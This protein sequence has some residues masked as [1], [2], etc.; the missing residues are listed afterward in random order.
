MMKQQDNL[1]LLGEAMRKSDTSYG[2]AVLAIVLVVTLL[3]GLAIS[4]GPTG[5]VATGSD[6]KLTNLWDNFIHWI[7]MGR[8]DLAISYGKAIL[9]AKP[10]PRKLYQLSIQTDKGG[11]TLSRGRGLKGLAPIIDKINTL[12]TAG[13]K[14]LRKD[15]AEIAKWI[16]MIGGTPR[17]LLIATER[18]AKSGEYAVPQ[19]IAKLTDK[20]TPAVLRTRLITI[21]PRLGQDQGVAARVSVVRALTAA[22]SVQDATVQ[23]AICRALGKIAY[24]QAG[25]YLKELSEKN[26]LPSVTHQA[27]LASLGACIGKAAKKPVAELFYDA[28]VKYYRHSESYMPDARYKTANVWY[29]KEGLGLCYKEVPREIFDEVYAMRSA[30][31]ALEHDP[32]FDPAVTLWIAANL[33]K[34]AELP[35]G[36]KDPTHQSGQPGA[37][38]Y[39]LASGAKYLQRV[40]QLS[41]NDG[42]VSVAIPAIQALARTAGTRNLVAVVEGGAQPLVS[43]LSYPSRKVRY[44]AAEALALA[45]PQKRFNGWNLVIPIL[46]EALRATGRTSAVLVDR[47]LDHRNKVKALLRDNGCDVV[48][49]ES[50]GKALSASSKQ[51][52]VDLIVLASNISTPETSKSISTIRANPALSLTPIILVA[53]PDELLAA[54]NLAKTDSQIV[55]LPEEK[56]DAKGISTAIKSAFTKSSGGLVSEEEA[57]QWSIRASKCLKLLAMTNNPVYDLTDATTALISALSDKRDEVRVAAAQALAEFPSIKAQRAI[58]NLALDGSAP[59]SVR[60]AAF[61]AA[62]ESFRQF[63]NQLTDDQINEIIN[64]VTGTGSLKIRNAAAQAMGAL[65]LRAEKVRQIVRSVKQL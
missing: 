36:V 27:A 14:A 48:D 32:D 3:T 49:A 6:K 38:Y 34:E 35:A 41:L 16:D 47:N 39:A 60:I 29:W 31:K 5:A 25:P 23:T 58:T 24:P 52:G 19:I 13:A 21:L 33:R 42:D 43:A 55:V 65:S 15:P 61:E 51:G 12:I 46:T 53:K 50:L 28:A 63:G 11:V 18:L 30:K 10:D 22:L 20:Q 9:N 64:E 17:Q 62:S 56:L 44:L 40:L 45:R 57:A 8:A 26:D 2:V 4:Q 1:V 37:E 7:R 59:E 54:R